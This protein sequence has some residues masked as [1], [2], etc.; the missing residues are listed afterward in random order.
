MWELFSERFSLL[1]D[2]VCTTAQKMMQVR[3][4]EI[5]KES[6]VNTLR[7]NCKKTRTKGDM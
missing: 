5:E 7:G 3:L 6:F 2:E 1:N 4:G